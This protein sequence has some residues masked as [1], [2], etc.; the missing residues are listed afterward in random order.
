MSIEANKT[1]VKRF[2]DAIQKQDF[3]EV[4]KLCHKDFVFYP[5]VD[6]PLVGVQAFIDAEKK[7]FDAFEGFKMPL[8]T[9]VA[10]GDRVA[11]Y[12]IFEGK[13]TGEFYGIAPKRQALRMSL[14]MLLRIADDKIIEKRAHYDMHDILRQLGA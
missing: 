12:L 9:M 5:Q 11:A 8:V 3:D 4:R 1:L 13:Q 6:R 14:L 2:Y 7:H 10:E